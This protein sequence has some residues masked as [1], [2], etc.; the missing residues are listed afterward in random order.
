MTITITFSQ[1]YARSRVLTWLN[2]I[3]SLCPYT[4]SEI[5]Y[6]APTKEELL[7]LH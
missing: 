5:T 6:S 2:R 1:P 7:E 3:L 4:P